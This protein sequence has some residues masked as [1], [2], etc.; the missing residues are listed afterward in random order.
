MIGERIKEQ[1]KLKG[2]TQKK[3][4]E[5]TGISL[6]A[7]EKYERNKLN[8]SYGKVK[9]IAGALG[10]NL[11][12]LMPEGNID[13]LDIAESNFERFI[14]I[15]IQGFMYDKAPKEIQDKVRKMFEQSLYID[16]LVKNKEVEKVFTGDEQI[17]SVFY[18]YVSRQEKEHASEIKSKDELIEVKDKMIL[19]YQ[20][21]MDEVL[22]G[23]RH[24]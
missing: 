23:L 22:R 6:S 7:I 15:H 9:F 11:C 17:A 24:E 8:P 18:D 2:L 5:M 10:I 4:A 13:E 21:T 3:L 14:D 16:M 20:K 12:D 1:R 19:S